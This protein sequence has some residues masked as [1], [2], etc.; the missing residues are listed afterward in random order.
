MVIITYYSSEQPSAAA[1]GG[2]Q[3]PPS[4]GGGLRPFRLP[5]FPG[6]KVKFCYLEP[7]SNV[8]EPD[9]MDRNSGGRMTCQTAT[10]LSRYDTPVAVARGC[11]KVDY[12]AG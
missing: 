3:A 12:G 2:R 11:F 6:E 1:F 10:S 8:P 7:N 4:F 9:A 5:V